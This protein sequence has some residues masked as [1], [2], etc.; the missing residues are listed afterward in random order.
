MSRLRQTTRTGLL[1]LALCVL[2]AGAV[3]FHASPTPANAGM[4]DEFVFQDLGYGH[5]VG[6]SQWGAWAAA[7]QGVGYP[8]ILGFYYEGTELSTLDPANPEMVVRL[9]SEPEK[10]VSTITQNFDQVE[11]LPVDVGFTLAVKTASGTEELP[12]ALGQ[13]VTLGPSPTGG[14]LAAGAFGER[15]AV[16]VAIRPDSGPSGPL[17]SV[18]LVSGGNLYGPRQYRGKLKV[19]P[20]T[21]VGYLAAY[22]YVSL[23][24][25]IRAIAEVYP[26]WAK[27][28]SPSYAFEAV[29]AQ[30]V[31]ARTYA[32]ANRDP[33]LNDNQ[34]D[35]VYRGY[36]FE[37]ANPGIRE[38]AEATRDV[39]LRYQG[40]LVSTYYSSNSG[41][42]TTF[43][44]ASPP[45]YLRA[46]A[47]PWSLEAPLSNPGYTWDFTVSQDE[48]T[49]EVNGMSRVGGGAV[50]IGT[51]RR[52]EVAERDTSDPG[53]H[54]RTL[55]VTGSTGTASIKAEDLRAK[56]GYGSMRSTLFLRIDNPGFVDVPPGHLYYEEIM[57]IADSG[58][59]NGYPSDEF[60]PQAPATRWQFAKMAVGLHNALD[61]GE[62]PVPDVTEA[63]FTDVSAQVGTAGDVSDWVAAAKEAGIVQGVTEEVFQPHREVRRDQVASMIVR[64][65]SWEDEAAAADAELVF[66]DVDQDN[67]HA[68]AAN[69]LNSLGILRG[70][71]DPADPDR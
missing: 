33:Y 14:L 48:V 55:E 57:G 47:D 63:P 49:N 41:G 65:M 40:T 64:A 10:S 26:E 46:K 68:V 20:S 13:G 52:I 25:Y 9:S 27:S 42:Y 62:I 7:R 43:W 34:W 17:F 30:A 53:S 69:Y 38:A 36:D 22:N 6:M 3:G 66:A 32:M 67:V 11:V 71:S 50:S 31:A 54:A 70:Y 24:G 5:G 4:T 23:E 21:T 28:D 56:F 18:T 12:V 59:V 16:E 15:D 35:Q 8:E 37:G 61:L 19:T 45:G 39:V 1:G 44:G 29:K 58:I 60:K 2:L 51:V